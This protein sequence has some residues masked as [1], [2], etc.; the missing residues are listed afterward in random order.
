MTISDDITPRPCWRAPEI[1]PPNGDITERHTVN[2]DVDDI[3]IQKL[4]ELP[5][6]ERSY[7]QTTTGSKIYVE[8]LQ[9]SVLAP[10][11]LV[12]KLGKRW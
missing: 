1:E 9:R 6:E 7:Q 11:N 4:A 2:V 12:I 10:E 5:G 8:N 3:N